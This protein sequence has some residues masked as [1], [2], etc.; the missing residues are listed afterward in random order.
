[1]APGSN[2]PRPWTLTPW[3]TAWMDYT[4]GSG[5]LSTGQRFQAATPRGRKNPTLNDKLNAVSAAAGVGVERVKIMLTGA[6]PKADRAGQHWLMVQTPDW[7]KHLG[8]WYGT[9]PTGRFVHHVTG[10]YLEVRTAAEWF[11]D[12]SLNPKEAMEAWSL[13]D[14]VLTFTFGSSLDSKVRTV[15][16]NSPA[17]TGTNLWAAAMPKGLDP[18]PL[19]PDVAEQLHATSGQHHLDHLVAGPSI[20]NHE[21]VVPL[22]DPRAQK[23]DQFAYVD[24]RFMYASL[25]RELG[26]GPGVR[27]GQWDT[28][29]LLEDNPYVRARVYVRFTVPAD[30]HHVGIFGVQHQNPAD[31][32]YYPNRPGAV[33]Q[34]WADA[35]EVFVARRFGWAVEPMESVVFNETMNHAHKRFDADA[36]RATRGKTKARPLDHW[37]IKLT[38]TR[39][40]IAEDPQIPAQQKKAL[41]AALR[42][43]LIQSIGAF[44]SRGRSKTVDV[45]D[46]REIPPESAH[47]VQQKGKAF[48]YEIPQKLNDRQQAF[49]HPEFAAQVWGRGR[50]KVLS[51]RAN[52]QDTGALM[53]PGETVIGINGDAI[54]TT[55]VPQWARPVEEGGADDGKTGRLRLQGFLQGPMPVPTSR[56]ERDKLR[57]RAVKNGPQIPDRVMDQAAF[58]F[59][60]E[61]PDDEAQ[62]Y[63]P[64]D[65]TQEQ[66]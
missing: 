55:A 15:L 62:T 31:G 4:S 48:V 52:H 19:D 35:S 63:R 14:S 12:A 61:T 34:T 37:A 43:I 30:W 45:Y 38:T 57:D 40:N 39:E 21:D 33:G 56:T 25:C 42:S 3:L 58:A 16:M 27:L 10:Q 26:T 18:V 66:A 53:L 5:I 59:E 65:E 8:Q 49:Y 50:A 13:L 6:V 51:G 24:G 2:R 9:P 41:G 7:S 29:E 47:T 1:M 11:G 23:I 36:G 32:W 46:A 60:W 64:A 20:A 22:I 17:A 54:Y 28:R 44:A